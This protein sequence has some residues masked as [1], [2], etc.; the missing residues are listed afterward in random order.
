MAVDVGMVPGIAIA[1]AICVYL[2]GDVVCCCCGACCL[3]TKTRQGEDC[4]PSLGF[5]FGATEG[6]LTADTASHV[7]HPSVG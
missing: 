3:R 4:A 2:V 5:T 6:Y 1:I 7:R